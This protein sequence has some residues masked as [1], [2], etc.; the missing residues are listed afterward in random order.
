MRIALANAEDAQDD[1]AQHAGAPALVCGG[2]H[3][4]PHALRF[5]GNSVLFMGN[6]TKPP[7]G[8]VIGACPAG[9]FVAPAAGVVVPTG[10]EMHARP[11]AE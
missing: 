7:I 5:Q 6:T 8:I 11:D 4:V 10:Q 9:T 1:H 2:C 3:R